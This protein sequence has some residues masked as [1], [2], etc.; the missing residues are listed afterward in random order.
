M[1][2]TT[3]QKYDSQSPSRHWNFKMDPMWPSPSTECGI[4]TKAKVHTSCS[5]IRPTLLLKQTCQTPTNNLAI[6]VVITWLLFKIV[7]NIFSFY[8]WQLVYRYIYIHTYL[9]VML[10]SILLSYSYHHYRTLLLLIVLI[11]Y[12]YVVIY[13][14]ISNIPITDVWWFRFCNIKHL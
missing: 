11:M 8:I 4:S 10:A 12:Y 9:L 5:F 2:Q 1:F 13:F 6:L 7:V 14:I 3:N